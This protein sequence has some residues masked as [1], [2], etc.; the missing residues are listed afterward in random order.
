MSTLVGFLVSSISIRG[1]KLSKYG[2]TE[3]DTYIIPSE[4]LYKKYCFCS[5]AILTNQLISEKSF[6]VIVVI[7]A[8]P[9]FVSKTPNKF[10]KSW[11]TTGLF[12]TLLLSK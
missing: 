12:P 4:G 10:S 1:V 7:V 2:S 11:I 3:D 9:V 6:D 8:G 5:V